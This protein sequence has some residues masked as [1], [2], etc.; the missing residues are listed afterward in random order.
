MRFKFDFVSFFFHICSFVDRSFVLCRHCELTYLQTS[1]PDTA[2]TPKRVE[3]TL[4]LFDLN[5]CAVAKKQHS[6]PREAGLP[7]VV[8]SSRWRH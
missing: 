4:P 8:L 3:G 1:V 7:K 6:L 5:A 2:E